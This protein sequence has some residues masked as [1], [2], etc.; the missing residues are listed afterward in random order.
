MSCY[1]LYRIQRLPVSLDSA[2]EF[3]SSPRNLKDI[4]PA[5]LQFE[6]LSNS[7]SEKM[8]AG[9]IITYY[10]RPLL[11]IRLF[12]MTEITH[13]QE[14]KYFVDEQRMGPYSFWH[15]THVFK[16]IP[17]GV[18]MVDMVHYQLPFG[19]LGKLAHRLFVKKQLNEIFD[20]RFSVLEKKFGKFS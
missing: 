13:M 19:I 15:H 7:N 16:E 5:Y 17:G 18:E 10:I 1:S 6:I 20:F 12:W 9:Q 8:F 11:G 3:F 2:W 14:K 4:T